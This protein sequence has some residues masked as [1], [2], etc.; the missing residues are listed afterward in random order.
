LLELRAF[1]FRQEMFRERLVGIE[2]RRIDT[3]PCSERFDAGAACRELVQQPPA[4]DRW[5]EFGS[6]RRRV[7]CELTFGDFEEVLAALVGRG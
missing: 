6:L 1:Q 7:L 5:F 2:V 3:E 4:R